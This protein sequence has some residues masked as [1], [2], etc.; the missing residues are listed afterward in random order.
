MPSDLTQSSSRAMAA[1]SCSASAKGK[2]S[3]RPIPSALVRH[4]QSVVHLDDGEVA[5]VRADGFRNLHP[6][7]RRHFAQETSRRFRLT[8]ESFDKEGYSHYMRKEIAEQPE[9]IRRT[10]SG[11]LDTA[12]QHHPSSA[13]WKWRARAAGKHPSREDSRLRLGVHR[14]LL[15]RAPDRATGPHTRACGARVR[16]FAIA[17]R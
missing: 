6:R 16:S 4:T 5:V 7:W 2:C 9:S 12:F 14:R 10:L 8:D 15:R 17:I 3:S 1:R 13:A 11:R